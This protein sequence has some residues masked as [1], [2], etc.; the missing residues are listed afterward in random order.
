M[1]DWSVKTRHAPSRH[2]RDA[3]VYGHTTTAMHEIEY[4]SPIEYTPP[5]APLLSSNAFPTFPGER[6]FVHALHYRTLPIL[7]AWMGGLL[8]W[9]EKNSDRRILKPPNDPIGRGVVGTPTPGLAQVETSGLVS[10]SQVPD[11]IS[12]VNTPTQERCGTGRKCHSSL[13]IT[14]SLIHCVEDS[15][16]GKRMCRRLRAI[17]PPSIVLFS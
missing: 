6:D 11:A 3:R 17:Q 12:T 13:F 16:S 7:R 8:S 15:S 10:L 5:P 4:I 2:C 14:V 9:E 1:S